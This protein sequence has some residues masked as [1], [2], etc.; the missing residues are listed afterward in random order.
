[1]KCAKCGGNIGIEDKICPYCGTPNLQALQHQEDMRRYEDAFEKTRQHVEERTSRFS[2]FAVPVTLG[3]ILIAMAVASVFFSASAY[4]IGR[5]VRLRGMKEHAG[6]Y[7]GMIDEYLDAGD[8]LRV[9]ALYNNKNLYYLEGVDGGEMQGYDMIFRAASYY[10]RIFETLLER[11][12]P[13][14]YLFREDRISTTCQ[15]LSEEMAWL[16]GIEKEDYFPK[17]CYTEDKLQAVSAMQ[18]QAQ[19]LLQTYA[20][21]SEEEAA[22]AGDLSKARLQAMLEEKFEDMMQEGQ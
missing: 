8:Y 4:D 7:A 16:F 13:D 18:Q 22:Q 5:S 1:M 12:E 20:G 15:D 21:F 10:S 3:L 17:S 14:N 19:M 6:E 2:G 9:N 11:L